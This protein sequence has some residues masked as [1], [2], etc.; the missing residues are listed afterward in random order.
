MFYGFGGDVVL[1]GDVIVEVGDIDF[2][3]LCGCEVGFV[4]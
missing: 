4:G 2:V 1:Y 3:D